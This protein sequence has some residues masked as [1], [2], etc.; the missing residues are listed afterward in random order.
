M[1]A[2]IAAADENNLIGRAN[3]LPWHLPVDLRYFKQTTLGK[4]VLMGRKTF[5]S[6]GKPLPGRRNVVLTRDASFTST[7]VEVVSSLDDALSL[8]ADTP[9]VMVVGGSE[10]YRLTL[11]IAQRV[12]LTRIHAQ[13]AG[14]AWF[15][16][17][18][19]EW[20]TVSCTRHEPDEKNRHAC[21]F[22]VLERG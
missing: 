7:G 18:G 3:G 8:L 13:F 22:L 2:L 9:E 21:S 19:A 6:V 14:D 15:P 1:I 17:L 12:Y 10:I 11:P 16:P 4:P 20:K 5:D